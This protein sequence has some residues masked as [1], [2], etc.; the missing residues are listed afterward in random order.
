VAE[1][2]VDEEGRQAQGVLHGQ[3]LAQCSVVVHEGWKYKAQYRPGLGAQME[4]RE[5]SEDLGVA[6]LIG[7][8]MGWQKC[9]VDAVDVKASQDPA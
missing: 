4:G 3:Q 1:L 5:D 2:A 6:D 8:K 7:H 9:E